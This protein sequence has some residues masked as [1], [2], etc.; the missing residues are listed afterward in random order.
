MRFRL[1]RSR[2]A[3]VNSGPKT[4]P[5]PRGLLESPEISEAYAALEVDGSSG[6]L[7][8]KDSSSD[9]LTKIGKE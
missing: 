4:Y 6:S 3:V 5:A 2:N 1:L 7:Q 9:P 8:S